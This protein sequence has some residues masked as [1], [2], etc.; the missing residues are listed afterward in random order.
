MCLLSSADALYLNSDMVS[1]Q[2]PVASPERDC[3]RTVAGTLLAPWH[4]LPPKGGSHQ[5]R[6]PSPESRPLHPGIALR[7]CRAVRTGS[8]ASRRGKTSPPA[9]A[10]DEA[11]P[12]VRRSPVSRLFTARVGPSL[13]A[14]SSA[15]PQGPHCG[16]VLVLPRVTSLR[17][18]PSPDRPCPR[19][20]HSW[21]SGTFFR[22]KAEATNPSPESRIPTLARALHR[23]RRASSTPA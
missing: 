14:Y 20:P 17:G 15:P 5:S 8:P 10:H 11:T 18:R 13:V 7:V 22:L 4:F 19:T 6:I 21:H 2:S 1:S 12:G 3:C 23:P 16:L 9:Q